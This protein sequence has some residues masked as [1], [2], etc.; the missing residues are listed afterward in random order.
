MDRV[1]LRK[2][3]TKL[4]TQRNL[5][6][7]FSTVLLFVVVLLTVL[8][9]SK[10]ER[11]VLLPTT[12]PSLWIEEKKVSDSYLEK[13]GF[14][15]ADLLL[16]RSPADV[17]RKNQ[18]IL[19]HVHPVFYHEIR[20]LLL[21]EK[22]NIVKNEQSFFFR[23]ERNYSDKKCET[24]ITEGEFMVFVGK[25]GETARCAQSERKKFILKFQ[26]QNGKLLLTSLK[27]EEV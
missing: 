24:F 2:N 15:L 5:F 13:M 7:F 8:L 25:N 16:N 11:I 20:K 14:F 3:V 19:E 12:G 4:V 26:C 21:Q 10:S 6:L 17:E 27:T 22:E 1:T 18:L 23:T 9:F